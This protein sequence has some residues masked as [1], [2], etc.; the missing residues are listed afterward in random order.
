MAKEANLKLP[1]EIL[2]PAIVAHSLNNLSFFLKIKPYLSTVGSKNKAYFNDEKY[3]KIFNL[4][5]QYYDKYTKYPSQITMNSMIQGKYK[6]DEDLRYA[7]EQTIKKVYEEDVQKTD[8]RYLEDE[9]KKFITENRVYEAMILSQL[10][11]ENGDFGAIAS[12]MTQAVQVNFDK[13]LGTSIHDVDKVFDEFED[14]SSA[15]SITTG[16]NNLD[17][18]LDGGWHNKE[19][20]CFAATPGLGKTLYLGNFALNAFMQGKKVLVYTFE[21]SSARIYSRLFTNILDKSKKDIMSD[22]QK[23]K[24]EAKTALSNYTGDII[25]KYFPANSASGNDLMAH[26]ND[27]WLYQQWKPDMIVA[28][29]ILIGCTNDKNLSSDN[30]YKYYKTVTEEW[31]NIA[32]I[33]DVPF[34]TASQINREGMDDKGGSKAITTAKDM[35]ESRGI[36]DTVDFFAT[37]NQPAK[38]RTETEGKVMMYIDKNRNGEKGHRLKQSIDYIHQRVS[39]V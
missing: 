30:S 38:D 18:I 16:L 21:T 4:I 37:L 39:E 25:V 14:I 23:S 28:D 1:S 24:D 7:L 35:S 31:R 15:S 22:L 3:Q 5:C 26:I 8:V 2:E 20:Y 10:D 13:D 17:A 34:L 6:E 29:Y 19:I 12:K 32:N 11:M 36:Y 9:T 33:L 27:L